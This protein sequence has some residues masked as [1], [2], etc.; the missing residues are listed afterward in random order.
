M[1]NSIT[2]GGVYRTFSTRTSLAKAT[3]DNAS[4][5]QRLQEMIDQVG[6]VC[7][8][9]KYVALAGDFNLDPSRTDADYY[10][11]KHLALWNA[12][13]EEWGLE[14]LRTSGPTYQSH[15]KF[16]RKADGNDNAASNT[17]SIDLIYTRT[18][19]N[20]NSTATVLPG[21]ASDHCPVLATIDLKVR[22]TRK[23]LVRTER[24][25]KKIN[26]A[27]LQSA[28]SD[29]DW[30]ELY[31]ADDSNT[32]AKTFHSCIAN[33]LD[34]VAPYTTFRTPNIRLRL[35]EDTLATMAKRDEARRQNRKEYKT[36]RNRATALQ[37][38]DW[39]SNINS[40]LKRN[41]NSAWGEVNRLR[42]K[43]KSDGGAPPNIE[44]ANSAAEAADMLNQA[45]V[46][47]P[48]KLR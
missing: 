9:S 10:A 31:A 38:R 17:S 25:F 47:K 48:M 44:G 37:R 8:S 22:S 20:N 5:Q 32:A 24:N 18:D 36:L 6:Q 2:I 1:N 40:N 27:A 14:L 15:G 34:V 29:T 46:D 7:E 23:L 12:A 43:T 3:R 26:A 16:R 45:F 33:I 39:I 19:G 13:A 4:M 35:K 42:G 30:T 28:I 11:S 41:P 21:A